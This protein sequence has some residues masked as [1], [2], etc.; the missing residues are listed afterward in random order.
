MTYLS[1]VTEQRF[2]KHVIC[3]SRYYSHTFGSML[4]NLSLLFCFVL[5]RLLSLSLSHIDRERAWELT[6]S[7]D[8]R[9]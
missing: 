9:E 7:C 8:L 4:A 6:Q 3:A 2:A 1:F 5:F